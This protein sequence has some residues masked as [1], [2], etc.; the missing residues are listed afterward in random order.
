MIQKN[1]WIEELELL[2]SIIRS[3]ELEETIKWGGPCFTINGKNVLG[4]G[5]FKSYVG[6]WFHQGVFLK[7]PLNVL[8]NASEG[9]TKGLRQWRFQSKKDINPKQ[10]KA[11]VLEA[12]ENAKAGKEIKPEKKKTIEIPAELKNALT[13]DKK[14]NAVF[15]ILTPFKQREYVEYIAE[16]KQEKTRLARIEKI[17]P[18]IHAG[19][20]LNDKYR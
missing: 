16:A 19:K 9:K 8:V 6:I 17:T 15:A 1:H 14:M 18:M 13:K 2:Y 4:L 3:T 5:G 7:D 20:G 11:Y 10:V 12:I